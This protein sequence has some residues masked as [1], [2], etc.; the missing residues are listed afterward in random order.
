MNRHIIT[1]ASGTRL[2]PESIERSIRARK[3]RS[4]AF[5]RQLGACLLLVCIPPG[6]VGLWVLW[7][8]WF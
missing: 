5:W 2:F 3:H 8:L 1:H 6:V 4:R 7:L